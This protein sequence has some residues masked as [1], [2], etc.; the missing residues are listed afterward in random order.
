MK[1][2][3][4]CC[5]VL[6]AT[7]ALDAQQLLVFPAV[8]DEQPGM[9]GSLWVTTALVVKEDPRDEV[10]IRRKWICLRGG[11]FADDPATAPTWSLAEWDPRDRML[12]ASG[13]ELLTGTDAT[14][15]AVAL[16]VDGGN[17]IASSNIMDVQWG[18]YSP[19]D[20]LAF[21]Q[22]QHVAGMLEPLDGP[23]HLPWLGGCTGTSCETPS[24]TQ[25]YV[26]NNIGIINPNSE[27]LVVQGTVLPFGYYNP[28]LG[29]EHPSEWITV[30]PEIFWKT[31]PAY[32]WRQFQWRSLQ[33]YDLQ[34]GPFYP[35]S[36]YIISLTT[37]KELPYYAYASVV[38]TPDPS[39]GV[40]FNDPMFIPAEPGYVMPF[41]ES[42]E[43]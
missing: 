32:G 29:A 2:G 35:R 18:E 12:H 19:D 26:R 13:A 33:D 8:T 10:T 11:G 41:D 5:L 42:L 20:K 24:P 38:F 9:N 40:V 31:I 39:S 28:N 25:Q 30:S 15:G 27:A 4:L 3:Y 22:G 21:G 36:G 16:E 6:L 43:P 1:N 37:D 14:V 17:V 7:A 34:W 23:S